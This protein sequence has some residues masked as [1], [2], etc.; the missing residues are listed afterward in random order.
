MKVE[1]AIRKLQEQKAEYLDNWV[2]FSRVA[3]A[4]DMA[5]E[6]LSATQIDLINRGRVDAIEEI[7]KGVWNVHELIDRIKALPSAERLYTHEEAW[8]MTD[9]ISRADAIEA[10]AEEWLSEASA[11]SPYVNDNDID[12]YR[13]LAEELFADI[14]S[15][16]APKGDLI[17]RQWLLEVYGDYIG[18]NGEPKYHVPLE[19]VRQNIKD[20][21]S[22]EAE[23]KCVAQIK[24]DTEEVARRI[25]EEYDITDGWVPCSE[26]LPKTGDSVLVTYSDGEVGIIRSARPKAWVTYIESNNLI[27]PIAWMPL[28][29]PYREDGE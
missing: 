2:D 7:S 26:R 1:E 9:L 12:R 5:I 8:G 16:D 3:E 27:Y 22:A 21:P 6:A 18:D 4:Y 15:A 25:K 29:K 14:P 20:A 28:P 17:S 11:E 19:V 24:V 10:V 13:E 23:T